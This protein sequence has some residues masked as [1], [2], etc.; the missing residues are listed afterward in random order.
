MTAAETRGEVPTAVT[1]HTLTGAAT[2]AVEIRH[3][4]FVA[5][6]LPVASGDDAA[7]AI[8]AMSVAEATHSCWA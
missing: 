7:R 4:R 2:H 3:S 6:A 8:H 1:L 5:H